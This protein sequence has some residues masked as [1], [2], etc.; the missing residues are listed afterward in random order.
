MGSDRTFSY[1]YS[2][3]NICVKVK[4]VAIE[5][6]DGN[7]LPAD[8]NRPVR[9]PWTAP[10]LNLDEVVSNTYGPTIRTTDDD[11]LSSPS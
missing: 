2:N 4:G 3:C 6:I 8:E 5:R 10:I 9:K 11:G 1:E 7:R